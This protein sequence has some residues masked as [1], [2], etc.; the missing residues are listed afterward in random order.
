MSSVETAMFRADAIRAEVAARV[1]LD[2][3]GDPRHR[4]GLE[5]LCETYRSAPLTPVGRAA[6]WAFLSRALAT[7]LHATSAFAARPEIID[8]AIDEPIYIVGLA[9]T[10][11]THLHRVLAEAPA[12]RTLA[13][14]EGL[15]PA[16]TSVAPDDRAARRAAAVASQRDPSFDVVREVA[17]DLPEEDYLLLEPSFRFA[18]GGETLWEPYRT[19]SM[20]VDM[21]PAYEE[22]AAL[23]RLL[24]HQLRGGRWLMK[25]PAHLAHLERLV[26]VFPDVRFVWTHRDPAEAVPS[27]CS[28]FVRAFGPL[29]DIDPCSVGAE[30]LE[31]TVHQVEQALAARAA[32]GEE[33][34]VDVDYR[35]LVARP[36]GVARSVALAVGLPCPREVAARFH[37]YV[38]AHP[39][40]AKGEHRYDAADYGLHADQIRER[41]AAYLDRFPVV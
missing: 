32:L 11:S 2:D 19:W 22:L 36:D 7:R 23:V 38:A 25:S 34:F 16:P 18:G 21:R 31:G 35:D 1:G 17:P 15:H 12:A 40:G 33:R 13:R 39:Q 28:L 9:R 30:L 27:L 8:R 26:E 6:K 29:A 5:V 41:F 3:F 4:E 20:Q 24:D 10:G 37:R 14:W